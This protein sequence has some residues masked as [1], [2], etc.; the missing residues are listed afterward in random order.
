MHFGFKVASA[1]K[2]LKF[3]LFAGLICFAVTL[4][5]ASNSLL[6]TPRQ[7]NCASQSIFVGVENEKDGAIARLTAANF[8]ASIEKQTVQ[9]SA[10]EPYP[11]RRIIIVFDT[12]GSMRVPFVARASSLTAVDL[13]RQSSPEIQFGFATFSGKF[14]MKEEF[15]ANHGELADKIVR[16]LQSMPKFTGSL[17][18]PNPLDS[19]IY[20][21]IIA[22]IDAF[23][24]QKAGDAVLV[25]T[26]GMDNASRSSQAATINRVQSSGVRLFAIILNSQYSRLISS[27]DSSEARFEKMVNGAGG[28]VFRLGT[29]Y[30]VRQ[31]HP[32]HIEIGIREDFHNIPDAADTIL[33]YMN[34]TYRLQIVPPAA[35]AKPTEWKLEVTANS[36][37]KNP[38]VLVRFQP[39]LLPCLVASER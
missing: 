11:L 15:T 13:V 34:T 24:S 26:D 36:G 4:A 25:V 17:S 7:D 3:A 16:D 9:V 18:A 32:K 35:I 1:K 22:G 14:E 33:R 27:E 23:G 2:I 20:D 28:E 21:A 12:S 6:L 29:E 38:S 19:G 37:A 10:A 31:T 5:R 8:H 39:Q 30:P